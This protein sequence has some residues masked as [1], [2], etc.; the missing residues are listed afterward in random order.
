M[1]DTI[2][3]ENRA[4]WTRR[5]PSYSEVNREEL[6]TNQRGIWKRTLTERIRS[7]FPDKLPGEIHVLEVGTGPG[8]FAILLAE[9]GYRVTAIDLTPSMLEEAQRNAGALRDRISFIEMNAQ[10]LDFCDER[11]DVILSRNVTWNL[12]EPE[13]AYAEWTRVLKPGGLLMNFDANWYHYL[14]D[15]QARAAY[16]L[17]RRNSAEEGLEDL[18][19][20]ENFDRMEQI[21]R[22]VP[23][24]R[25]HRPTWD[26][27][28]LSGL[29]MAVDAD[30]QVWRRVWSRQEKVNL[31]STPMFM[32]C[33]Y[34]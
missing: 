24:S 31:A 23:L 17:D 8:F 30:L 20:G 15:D 28:T 12:P 6:A 29:G 21:A 19:V 3:M 10:A 1:I 2:L 32:V 14:F 34:K 18:N 16:E 33:G 13:R 26:I 9:V 11:F 27:K 25:E 7:C 4:Y 5:A 22:R